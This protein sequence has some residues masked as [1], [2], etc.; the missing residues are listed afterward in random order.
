MG[1]A[2]EAP[3]YQNFV[4]K[5]KMTFSAG[6]E[7]DFRNEYDTLS[8]C[9]GED[10]E[11]LAGMGLISIGGGKFQ[12]NMLARY[13]IDKVVWDERKGG[14]VWLEIVHRGGCIATFIAKA[15]A[16]ASKKPAPRF[17]PWHIFNRYKYL[18]SEVTDAP[19]D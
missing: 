15:Q 10:A 19:Q 16:E 17:P 14:G 2:L 4:M 12:K 9:I 8:M 13:I 7:D 18:L 6:A 5:E 3:K 11:A 1:A